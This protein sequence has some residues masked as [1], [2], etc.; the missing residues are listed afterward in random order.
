[1]YLRLLAVFVCFWTV[2]ACGLKTDPKPPP[3]EL[4]ISDEIPDLKPDNSKGIK[5]PKNR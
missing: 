1:M 3:V 2:S 5:T 4:E